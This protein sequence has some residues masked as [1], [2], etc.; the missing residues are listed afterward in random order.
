MCV[1]DPTDEGGHLV[2]RALLRGMMLAGIP[3]LLAVGRSAHGTLVKLYEMVHIRFT[4]GSVALIGFGIDSGIE[5]TAS[6]VALWRLNA[7]ADLVRRPH[8]VIACGGP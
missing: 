3:L 8:R 4:A 7:D 6:I 5:L 2:V 1:Q